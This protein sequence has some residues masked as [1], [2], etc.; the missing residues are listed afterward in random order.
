MYDDECTRESWHRASPFESLLRL[1]HDELQ[2]FNDLPLLP[3]RVTERLCRLVLLGIPP[4]VVE[5]DLLAFGAALDELQAR[6]GAAFAPV[7]GSVYAGVQS[8]GLI[9]DLG[10]L[11]LSGAGQSSG[12]PT[13]YAFGFLSEPERDLVASRFRDRYG[14]HPAAITWTKAANQGAVLACADEGELDNLV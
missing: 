8:E 9:A 3:D 1:D 4:A 13:L 5:R 10:R 2:A 11:G 6:I 12:G 14:L 7:Q